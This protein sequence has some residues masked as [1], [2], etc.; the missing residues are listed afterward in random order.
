MKKKMTALCTALCC[1]CS[2]ASLVVSAEHDYTCEFVELEDGGLGYIADRCSYGL[3]VETGDSEMTLDTLVPFGYVDTKDMRVQD[4][5]IHKLYTLEEYRE[6]VNFMWYM[7]EGSVETSGEGNVY[8]IKADYMTNDELSTLARQ[9]T[10]EL[11]FV[12][13]VQIINHVYTATSVDFQNS[14]CAKLADTAQDPKSIDFSAMPELNGFAVSDV[15]DEKFRVSAGKE[16]S[17]SYLA[18]ADCKGYERYLK[19]N[20][21]ADS[22]QEKYSDVFAE[23]E[24]EFLLLES[25]EA[26]TSMELTDIWNNAGDS[27]SDGAVDA[28]DAA[29]VLNIAAQNGTGA[30][31][32]ATAADDVNADGAV[33]AADAAAVLCYAAAK[34]TGADVSWVDIL[35]R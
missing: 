11:D 7:V 8:V 1:A 33:N 9:L 34:G 20:E 3:L 6:I 18:A 26:P 25:G 31:I 10:M 32:K 21:F 12:E 2:M 17:E 29:N 24:P 13:N 28:S 14:F 15:H 5:D 30:N 35:R 16:K 22:V 4:T 27:N 23:F 19:L